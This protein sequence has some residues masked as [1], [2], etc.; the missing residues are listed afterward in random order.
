MSNCD[1]N[2]CVLPGAQS[3]TYSSTIILVISNIINYIYTTLSGWY[4]LNKENE[5]NIEK[6]AQELKELKNKVTYLEDEPNTVRKWIGT[7][8]LESLKVYIEITDETCRSVKTNINWLH[9]EPTEEQVKIRNTLMN[10]HN[11]PQNK[12]DPFYEWTI[13][14]NKAQTNYSFLNGLDGKLI[15]TIKIEFPDDKWLPMKGMATSD[16]IKQIMATLC[17]ECNDDDISGWGNKGDQICN[18]LLKQLQNRSL[19]DWTTTTIAT[20]LS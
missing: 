7:Y 20:E 10:G 19:I 8:E 1:G 14:D 17:L 18:T 13:N 3:A 2:I 12:N 16:E 4:Y 5:K 15:T 6:L 9:K 11:M